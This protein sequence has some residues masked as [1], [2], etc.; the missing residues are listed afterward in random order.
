MIRF[1]AILDKAPK[2]TALLLAYG[3]FNLIA[4]TDTF[5]QVFEFV[6]IVQEDFWSPK[7]TEFM[8]KGFLMRDFDRSINGTA[9]DSHILILT[10]ASAEST[11]LKLGHYWVNVIVGTLL[12]NL[13]PI[14]NNLSTAIELN[15]ILSFSSL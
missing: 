15:F 10:R 4:S 8:H 5:A 1:K 7:S 2:A 14:S 9:F 13:K 3:A 6:L 11:Y 12:K